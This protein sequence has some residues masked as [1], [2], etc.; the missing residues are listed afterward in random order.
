MN[1]FATPICS[2]DVII[3]CDF[4]Y[5]R[6]S[7]SV[8]GRRMFKIEDKSVRKFLFVHI[9]ISGRYILICWVVTSACLTNARVARMPEIVVGADQQWRRSSISGVACIWALGAEMLYGAVVV[10]ISIG[11]QTS[12]TGHSCKLSHMNKI[13]EVL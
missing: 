5:T 11:Y 4:M 2:F 6:R 9:L 13:N 12:C 1:F 3:I 8:L 10:Q 7:R